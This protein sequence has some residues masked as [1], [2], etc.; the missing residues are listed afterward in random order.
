MYSRRRTLTQSSIYK[1]Q[2]N[3]DIERIE[4][5][6]T[7]ACNLKCP[8]CVRAITN[9]PDENNYRPLEEIIAQLDSYPNLKFV[10][11]AG[12]ISEPTT[13]PKLLELIAYINKRNIEISLYINGDT[14]NDLYYKKLGTLFRNKTGHVYF[15]ICGSTQELHGTYRVN[16]KLDRVLSRLEIVDKFSGGKGVLT[17]IVFNYNEQDFI[18][19]YP[20]FSERYNTE[21]FHTLPITEHHQ[22]KSKIHLPDRL[23]A[24]YEREIDRT[25]FNNI[26][27]PANASNYIQIRHD[28]KIDPCSLYRQ[29][30]E[31]HCW[32]CSNKNL[33]T[34]RTNKIFQCAE[35]ETETSSRS[36]LLYYERHYEKE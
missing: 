35:P 29:F 13:Y 19:N 4:L 21:Y 2:P 30:G 17:W 16:S 33:T 8:L 11:I 10:T 24:L 7:S 27:C 28:G 3:A 20:K 5:E 22:L 6:L 1:V 12:P 9:V 14:R 34:L 32:E 23:K 26:V 18:E 36:V 15:T 31:A 25:D